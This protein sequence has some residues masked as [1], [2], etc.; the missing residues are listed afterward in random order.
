MFVHYVKQH[1]YVKQHN[2]IGKCSIYHD[3]RC[4]GTCSQTQRDDGMI[5]IACPRK[6]IT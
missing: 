5:E 4:D 6:I 3:V 2:L 1:L